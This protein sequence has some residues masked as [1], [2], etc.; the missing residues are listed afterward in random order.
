MDLVGVKLDWSSKGDP[1]WTMQLRP[2]SPPEASQSSRHIL[3]TL[4]AV[5]GSPERQAQSLLEVLQ[6]I[7]VSEWGSTLPY[8]RWP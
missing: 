2:M 4:P 8:R 6:S 3:M 1:M 5:D 7:P